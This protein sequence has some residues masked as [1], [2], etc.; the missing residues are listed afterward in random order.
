MGRILLR[1]IGRLDQAIEFGKYL[2]VHDPLNADA[3]FDLGL[4]YNMRGIGPLLS[5]NTAPSLRSARPQE[6]RMASSGKS[7]C[8]RAMRKWP[9]RRCD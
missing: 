2:V 6:V 8:C 5:R 7:W 4:A 3:H 1:R 9:S